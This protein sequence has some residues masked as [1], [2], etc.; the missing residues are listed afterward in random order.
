MQL[1]DLPVGDLEVDGDGHLIRAARASRHSR[2]LSEEDSAVTIHDES[3]DAVDV[4][5]RNDVLA[6]YAEVVGDL[7]RCRAPAGPGQ[8]SE[9]VAGGAHPALCATRGADG[10]CTGEIGG[11]RGR[12]DPALRKHLFE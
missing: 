10:R 8:L 6:Q 2:E 5:F 1:D 12:Q 11:P 3:F 9:K 7:G 4:L